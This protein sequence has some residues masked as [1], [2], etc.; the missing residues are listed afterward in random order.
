MPILDAPPTETLI[1]AAAALG[2]GQP[3]PAEGASTAAHTHRRP[4]F[5]YPAVG[6]HRFASG[7]R[8]VL[9]EYIQRILPR[10][11]DAKN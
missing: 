6:K 3:R 11:Q 1:A 8:A 2:I 10:N 7:E 5:D 4:L 9:F